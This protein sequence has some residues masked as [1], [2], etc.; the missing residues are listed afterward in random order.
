MRLSRIALLSATAAFAATQAV[1][2]ATQVNI[3]DPTVTTRVARVE[4]G[5]RLAVQEVAPSTFFHHQTLGI[6]ASPSCVAIATTP[7]GKALVIRQVRVN[8]TADPSPGSS[9]IIY[10]YSGTGCSAGTEAG[11]VNP[12]TV[13]QTTM[14]FDPGLAIPN[15]S[16]MSVV[17]HGSLAADFYADGY[18]VAPAVAP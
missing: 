1:A 18:S 5:N 17:V 6:A 12:P 11:T 15:G 3:L 10:V 2:A 7:A 9:D 13:G 8:V 14:T 16:G 4:Q